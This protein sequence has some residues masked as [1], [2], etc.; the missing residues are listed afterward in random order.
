MFTNIQY[1]ST[2]YACIRETT[3]QIFGEGKEVEENTEE[4]VNDA[5]EDFTVYGCVK[6]SMMTFRCF[7]VGLQQC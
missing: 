5:T 7:K 4:E 2:I 1:I 3:E 6:Q